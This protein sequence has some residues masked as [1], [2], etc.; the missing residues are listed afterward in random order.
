MRK[1]ILLILLFCVMQHTLAQNNQIYSQNIQSLQ[2]M[3]GDDWL[4]IPVVVL[5]GD[6]A[7]NIDFDDMTHQYCCYAYRV[8]HCEADWTESKD[9]FVSDYI[10]GFAQDNLIEDYAQSINTNYEYTHYHLT[11][12]ND[13]CRMKISGNYKL[14][15]YDEDTDEDILTACFMVTERAMPVELSYTT[16]T[17]ADINGRH[18]Q[19]EASLQYG[20]LKVTDSQ[21]ELSTCLMQ[22][23]CYDDAAIDASPSFI[24][25]QGLEWTHCRQYIFNG[26]NEYHKFE[27]LQ[28]SNVGLGIEQTSWDGNDWHAYLYTDEPRSSYVYDQDANGAFLIRNWDG[29]DEDETSEYVLM[30]FALKTPYSDRDVYLDGAWTNHQRSAKYKMEY[31]PTTQLYEKELLLKQGYYSYRYVT[32][33]NGRAGMVPLMSEGNFYQTENRY[34]FLVYYR[35][36][37]A[38]TDRL[39]GYSQI[40]THDQH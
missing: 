29:V 13:N 22:N 26:G 6:V 33:A 3:A 16:V 34:Q 5:N 4:S 20:S 38:R 2:V 30:H 37:G 7:V 39:V 35:P 15:V 31:N 12:P 11:L 8:E 21:R 32:A 27:T 28:T 24:T 14:T 19:L 18:Q 23:G 10:E 9:I 36:I 17:D 25:P 40:S 1:Y